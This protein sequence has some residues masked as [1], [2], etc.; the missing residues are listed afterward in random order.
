[1]FHQ[2]LTQWMPPTLISTRLCPVLCRGVSRPV[3]G[4]LNVRYVTD[5][6]CWSERQRT[7][8]WRCRLREENMIDWEG[9]SAPSP[10][11]GF[12]LQQQHLKAQLR[13]ELCLPLILQSVQCHCDA[14]M[15]GFAPQVLLKFMWCICRCDCLL[16][17][18]L[19][20]A[21]SSKLK[22]LDLFIHV[23][24]IFNFFS[25]LWYNYLLFI[26]Y[27]LG[28]C[29]CVWLCSRCCKFSLVWV[30]EICDKMMCCCA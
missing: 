30:R 23:W 8:R 14:P 12:H 29:E 19:A 1:M 27:A 16:P 22:T 15:R 24:E 9:K 4:A 17:L 20:G 10:P 18:D 13:A 2:V 26:E 3:L 25:F 5:C 21:K 6:F 28:V 7:K 11:G